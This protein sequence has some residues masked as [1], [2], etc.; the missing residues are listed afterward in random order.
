MIKMRIGIPR[1]NIAIIQVR[2]GI[3]TIFEAI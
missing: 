2:F 3:I 1:I